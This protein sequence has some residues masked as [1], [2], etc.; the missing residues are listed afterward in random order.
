MWNREVLTPV[1]VGLRWAVLVA[2]G[3]SLASMACVSYPS[4][5]GV[6][7]LGAADDGSI[8]AMTYEEDF[9][10]LGRQGTGYYGSLDGGL[11]WKSLGGLATS[12][13]PDVSLAE[14]RDWREVSVDTPRGRYT[15]DGPDVILVDLDGRRQ[16]AYSTAYLQEDGNTWVKYRATTRHGD[17]RILAS[18]PKD[19][20]YD[21]TSGNLV[22][23]MG[24]QG[25]V[26]GT[27]DGEWVEVGVGRFRP[28]NFNFMTKTLMLLTHVGF[29]ITALTLAVSMTA[30]GL[31]LSQYRVIRLLLLTLAALAVCVAMVI[32][33]IALVAAV[34]SFNSSLALLIG[35]LSPAAIVVGARLWLETS[36]HAVAGHFLDHGRSRLAA[37]F[38]RTT[39]ECWADFRWL[40][41]SGINLVCDNG[42]GVGAGSPA[43]IDG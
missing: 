35:L 42:V 13:V 4:V 34:A 10:R 25:V 32:G 37:R 19:L 22:L 21:E 39:L 36:A 1:A 8:V 3:A 38:G 15:R 16:V 2:G 24:I 29:W 9:S 18:E 40:P 6:V 20:I 27:P 23:A 17:G 41:H 5:A 30:A 43:V 11:T 33:I 12:S 26:V 14:W 28:A 7:L 31:V